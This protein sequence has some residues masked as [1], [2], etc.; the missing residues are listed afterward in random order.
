MDE[1]V[2]WTPPATS[3]LT[4]S[5][6]RLIRYCA[7]GPPDGLPVIFHSGSPG[8]RWKRAAVIEAIEQSGLRMLV[9]D[10]PGYGGSTRQRGRHIAFARPWGFELS[11]I[12]VPVTIWFGTRDAYG[13]GHA[14][15]LL[16]HI[17]TAAG[18]E[19]PGGHIQDN[20]A[21]R[22]MLAWLNH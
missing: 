2:S 15:R 16:S 10:R 18:H 14:S 12:T 22:Q 8:T 1:S 9:P 6:G 13:R 21:Y 19:Y 17:P 5:D 7:Y 20:S 3:E 4:S 11:G